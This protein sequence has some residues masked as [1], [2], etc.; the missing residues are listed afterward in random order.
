MKKLFIG[1][2]VL[3]LDKGKQ[4][5]L[6][7]FMLNGIFLI[8]F[9]I[10]LLTFFIAGIDKL[11]AAPPSVEVRTS[12]PP[13]KESGVVTK[14]DSNKPNYACRSYEENEINLGVNEALGIAGYSKNEPLKNLLIAILKT[15]SSFGVNIGVIGGLLSSDPKYLTYA[16]I[17]FG[18]ENFSLVCASGGEFGGAIGP[19]QI[20]PVSLFEA[21]GLI[22]EKNNDIFED[23]ENI[24]NLQEKLNS[25]RDEKSKIEVDGFLGDITKD[26]IFEFLSNLGY[27][28]D[29]FAGRCKSQWDKE[30]I[31]IC[32]KQIIISLLSTITLKNGKVYPLYE[33]LDSELLDSELPEEVNGL[34]L[35][36]VK[37]SALTAIKILQM[38]GLKITTIG[39]GNKCLALKKYHGTGSAAENYASNVDESCKSGISE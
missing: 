24:K 12:T 31:G 18:N 38:K 34:N 33:L 28:S 37:D 25:M 1:F 8:S 22:A 4:F 6:I 23:K 5:I 27:S 14:D 17:L 20:L 3:F 32:I 29:L 21:N 13:K 30:E 19:F 39:I 36:S 26:A 9:I 11:E 15:E 16:L 2:F 10:I 7:L 35:F